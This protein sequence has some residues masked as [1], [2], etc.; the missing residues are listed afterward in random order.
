MNAVPLICLT[1]LSSLFQGQT[2]VAQSP[3]EVL[4]LIASLPECIHLRQQLEQGRFGNGVE[5]PYMRVMRD[6]GMQRA[7][8][9]LQGNWRH[10]HPENLQ[11]VRRLY[12]NRL[13]LPDA[14]IRGPRELRE[15]KDSGLENTLDEAVLDRTKSAHFYAGVDRWAG[16]GREGHLRW[17]HSGSKI[18]GSIELFA[19]P[20]ATPPMPDLVSPGAPRH[21]LAGIAL[22]GDATE[23]SRILRETGFSQPELDMALNFALM[24]S[25]DNTA[26]IDALIKAGA[27]VN[28]KFAANTTP[29]MLTYESPCNIPVLLAHGAR[30]GDRDKWGQTALDH[31][32]RRHDLTSIQLLQNAKVQQ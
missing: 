8:F 15:I 3:P 11:I 4:K 19:N 20:W 28:A 31:A 32:R 14:Q 9:E 29:L 21:D 13:D 27:N 7:F 2:T 6:H 16:A 22:L 10:S 17:R 12:Y 25:W 1:L 26:V 24:S 5:Q 23:L 30:I 18:R